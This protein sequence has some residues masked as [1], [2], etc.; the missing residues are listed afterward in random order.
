MTGC[1]H[2]LRVAI[3]R[4]PALINAIIVRRTYT[5][6]IRPRARESGGAGCSDP[7]RL[8]SGP[9]IVD[10]DASGDG[11]SGD[12][13]SRER[14]CRAAG[15]GDLDHG[16]IYRFPGAGFAPR[17]RA[18]PGQR[19]R[20]VG[21]GRARGKRGGERPVP[22][23]SAGR[24]CVLIRC[25]DYFVNYVRIRPARDRVGPHGAAFRLSALESVSCRV[26]ASLMTEALRGHQRSSE[27]IRSSKASRVESS[28]A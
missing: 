13:T 28:R 17:T 12:C 8:W 5:A 27:V 7:H 10:T 16:E 21:R 26:V 3:P 25:L 15:S 20:P 6:K 4:P 14:S 11:A 9:S 18:P 23:P 2:I 19:S 24:P 22:R 1:A